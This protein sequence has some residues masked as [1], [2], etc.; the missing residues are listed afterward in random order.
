MNFSTQISIH[1][2]TTVELIVTEYCT[3][4]RRLAALLHLH[5]SILGDRQALV[6]RSVVLPPL[7]T[8]RGWMAC[9]KWVAI[10]RCHGN[11]IAESPTQQ[12]T[13]LRLVPVPILFEGGINAVRYTA[14]TLWYLRVAEQ[15]SS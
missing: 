2:C 9:M 11:R 13:L 6:V 4:R 1:V 3:E 8:A 10:H 15:Q 12:T 7:Y 5:R 14:G